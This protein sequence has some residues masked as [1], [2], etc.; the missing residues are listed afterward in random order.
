ML[1]KKLSVVVG[2]GHRLKHCWG[3]AMLHRLTVI[4]SGLRPFSWLLV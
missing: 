4:S 2:L 1:E 3:F